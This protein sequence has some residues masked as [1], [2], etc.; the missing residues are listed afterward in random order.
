MYAAPSSKVKPLE[1]LPRK[2]K[3]QA[4]YVHSLAQHTQDVCECR[5]VERGR[6]ALVWQAILRLS[7]HRNA[8]GHL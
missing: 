2:S 4:V 3:R 8:Y 7:V 5:C 1:L 6:A